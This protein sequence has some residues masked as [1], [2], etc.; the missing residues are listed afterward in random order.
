MEGSRMRKLALFASLVLLVVAIA[1]PASATKPGTDP[2]LE[3]G[4]KIWICHAT[5]SLSNPYVKILIDIAAWDIA[6]PDSNDHGPD[7]HAREKQDVMWADY[8]LDHPDDECVIPDE[9][10]PSGP[11]CR[12]ADGQPEVDYVVEFPGTKLWKGALTES[13]ALFLDIKAGEY[14]VILIS[15]DVKRGDD[16]GEPLEQLNEQ[17]RLLGDTNSGYSND[18]PDTVADIFGQ[19]TYGLSVTFNSSV[20]SLT[21]E[22]WSVAQTSLS[23]DSVVPQAACLKWVDEPEED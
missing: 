4:H 17:W 11:V 12:W 15:S 8:A 20:S 7:H 9:P 1:A 6:D 3:D 21:A 14:D 13:T 19:V 18:L 10:P 23:P 2:E 22:H 5:R 16:G